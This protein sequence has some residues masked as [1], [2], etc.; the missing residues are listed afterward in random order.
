MCDVSE[1]AI[2]E[3]RRSAELLGLS[4]VTEFRAGA[5]LEPARAIQ[6]DVLI[7]DASGIPDAIAEVSRNSLLGVT[8]T[9]FEGSCPR[10]RCG[11]PADAGEGHLESF[12]GAGRKQ[13]SVER[14]D[15]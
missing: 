4:D 7:G 3:A 10:L 9:G 6:A 14:R 1:E 8:L 15:P 11:S 5:L 2:A 13:S 12:P